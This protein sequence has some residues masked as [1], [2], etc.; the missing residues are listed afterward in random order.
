MTD[1]MIDTEDFLEHFG[2]KGMKWGVHHAIGPGG[3]VNSKRVI[4]PSDDA[5]EVHAIR[6][7]HVSELSNHELKKLT[8]R[9]ELEKKYSA[10]NPS[11]VK[12][13]ML[14]A[15]SILAAGT[16]ITSIYNLVNSNA[17]KAGYK[18]VNKHVLKRGPGGHPT[19]WP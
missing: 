15:G 8:Q 1:E 13:G 14:I 2:I 18:I 4:T 7:K 5:K 12:R 9:A 19:L 6:Q 16:T 17:F 11:T 10:I 3:R